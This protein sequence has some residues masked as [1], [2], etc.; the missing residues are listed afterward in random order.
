MANVTITEELVE[1][2]RERILP[3]HAAAKRAV[4]RTAAQKAEALAA[5]EAIAPA[6][7]RGARD[8]LARLRELR[9]TLLKASTLDA[10]LRALV[11]DDRD[12]ATAQ[13]RAVR[14]GGLELDVPSVLPSAAIDLIAP[15]LA[16]A[17]ESLVLAA[18]Y[19]IDA[20]GKESSR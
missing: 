7:A 1:T 20:R 2:L 15:A 16:Q 5:F 12:S 17:D 11:A 13:D 8:Y 10:D 3:G 6:R 18:R 14:A 9:T 19:G 4:E